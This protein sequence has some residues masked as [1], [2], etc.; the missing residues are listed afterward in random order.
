MRVNAIAPGYIETQLTLDWWSEQPDPAKAKQAT[1]DLAA[2]EAHGRAGGSGDDRRVPRVR[3]SAVHQRKL[4][5][6]GRRTFI[7]VS[8]L[9]AWG[10]AKEHKRCVINTG[11]RKW[12]VVSKQRTTHWPRCDV[13]KKKTRSTPSY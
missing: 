3:R 1:L 6:G 7:A 2:D 10:T 8:R 4:H 13:R 12:N 11:G 5:H 9:T